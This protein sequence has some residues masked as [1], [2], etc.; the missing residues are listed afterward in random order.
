MNIELLENRLRVM[1]LQLPQVGEHLADE[2]LACLVGGAEPS[3]A[4]A[5]HLAGCD[6]CIELMEALGEGWE[7]LATE[8]PALAEHVL[9]PPQRARRRAPWLVVV[10]GLCAASA[11][12]AM[13]GRSARVP[14]TEALDGLETRLVADAQPH[15]TLRGP[16]APVE[17][18]APRE[19]APV[20]PP[21]PV[22]PAPVEPPSPVQVS[23]TGAAFEAAVERA[24]PRPGVAAMRPTRA[25]VDL[26][27][28]GP[29]AR[30]TARGPAPMERLAVA[31]PPR[32]FGFLRLGAKPNAQ[33]F[34]DGE[35]FGWTPL[36]DR[37]LPEGPHD[38]R[39]V[40]ESP[41]A[42]KREERFRVVIEPDRV[43]RSLRVNLRK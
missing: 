40:F 35:P 41:L 36:V 25:E 24:E 7:R 21:L 9:R 18:L 19:P 32:G 27:E 33:V 22:D 38:I 6:V 3:A 1:D 28:A 12:A 2:R 20:E 31:G 37:R 26:P 23:S 39:L 34:V 30:L 15:H 11:A 17:Q 4:E 5:A 42:A 10:A 14:L 29:D 43:W 8:Q 13:Y 16:Q